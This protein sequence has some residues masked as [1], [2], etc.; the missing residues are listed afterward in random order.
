MKFNPS[1]KIADSQNTLIKSPNISCD[2]T[3]PETGIPKSDS[4]EMVLEVQDTKQNYKTNALKMSKG[5]MPQMPLVKRR[6]KCGKVKKIQTQ[7]MYKEKLE[8]Q[9]DMRAQ[10]SLKSKHN[11][12]ARLLNNTFWNSIPDS[13]RKIDNY[14]KFKKDLKTHL[15]KT[16]YNL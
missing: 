3:V 13:L 15:F 7:R 1:H 4:S 5:S 8:S 16:Y 11:N 10:W 14:A 2:S 12:N 6:K 9:L